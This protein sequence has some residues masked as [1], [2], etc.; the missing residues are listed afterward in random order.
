MIIADLLMH[1]A[2]SQVQKSDS[3]NWS[4]IWHTVQVASSHFS[5]SKSFQTEVDEDCVEGIPSAEDQYPPLKSFLLP[6]DP[7]SPIHSQ[8]NVS[9]HTFLRVQE[10][11][12]FRK[13]ISNVDFIQ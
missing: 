6:S 7:P 12:L 10:Q 2:T 4:W 11:N 13:N 8:V 3:F 1:L 9:S 5:C